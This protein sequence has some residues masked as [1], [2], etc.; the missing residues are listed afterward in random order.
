MN[1]PKQ[2]YFDLDQP[3]AFGRADFMVMPSNS[4]ALSLIDEWPHWPSYGAILV[5]PEGSGKSHLAHVWYESA[6]CKIVPY[7]ELA[8]VDLPS[9]VQSK[10]LCIEDVPD[11]NL[12][13]T[14]LFHLLNLAK[15]T[16][17]SLLLTAQKAPEFWQIKLPDLVSR[18]RALPIVYLMPPDDLLLRNVLVKHFVDRQISVDESIISYLILRMPRSLAAARNL[19]TEIDRRALQDGAEITRPFVAKV[20]A[21]SD[22]HKFLTKQRDAYFADD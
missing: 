20:L 21:E 14:E 6:H 18:L 16:G 5:G 15:Q 11:Q 4:A 1:K 13:E 12:Q 10:A 22:G 7:A 3:P 8:K 9:L 19:V 17:T 2:L